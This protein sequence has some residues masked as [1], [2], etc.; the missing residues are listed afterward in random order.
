[1]AIAP[2]RWPMCA[3]K[4][5]ASS[6]STLRRCEPLTNTYRCRRHP[7]VML[8]GRQE[9]LPPDVN[10]IPISLVERVEVLPVS[11]S[12]LYSGNPVGGVINIVLRP[13]VKSTEVTTTCTN[14][15]GG[16]DAPQFSV[17]L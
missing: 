11:A 4:R 10:F 9:T 13:N 17:S 1:M 12:A 2:S 15:L 3:W 7:E 5:S 8:S 14:A 16:F 6:T